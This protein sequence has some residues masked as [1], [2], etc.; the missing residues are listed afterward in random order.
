MSFDV[1][2]VCM[3]DWISSKLYCT[4]IVT[5]NG[6]WMVEVRDYFLNEPL[7]PNTLLS[8]HSSYYILSFTIERATIFC[9]LLH[10]E[11]AAEPIMKQYPVVERQSFISQAPIY[12]NKTTKNK[13]CMLFVHQPKAQSTFHIAKNPLCCS[14]MILRWFIH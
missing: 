3:K 14:K 10:H 2:C 1:F 6:N 11:I 13:R 9:F 5:M 4:F 12:I 8:G 7:K